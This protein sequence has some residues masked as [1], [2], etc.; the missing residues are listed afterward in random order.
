MKTMYFLQKKS[1][2]FICFSLLITSIYAGPVGKQKAQL[3]AQNFMSRE[4]KINP[5]KI[6]TTYEAIMDANKSQCVMHVFKSENS[7]IVVAADDR[8]YPILAYSTEGTYV[9]KGKVPAF[10][11]WMDN[12]SKEIAAESNFKSTV[13]QEVITAWKLY[14]SN[15]KTN[16]NTKS[17]NVVAPLVATFWNQD[18]DYNYYCPATTIAGA[19]DGKCYAGCVA[20]AMSQVMKHYNYPQQ[21]RGSYSYTH[22]AFGLLSADFANTTYNWSIM[23]PNN[24]TFIIDTV[25]RNA[26][27]K[28]MY[29]C[30]VS[31]EMDYAP[32]GSG[33]Q[34]EYAR[35]AL[36]NNFKYRRYINNANK[37]D[38]T[39]DVWRNMLMEN[40]DMGYPMIYSG[41]PGPGQTGHAWV[42]DGYDATD[43]FHFNFGW[44][45]SG[46][47]YLYLNNINSGNG[48]FSKAQSIVYNIVPDSSAYP[49]CIANKIYTAQNY[50]FTDGSYTD[51][52][53]NN[54]NCQWLIQPDT[55]GTDTLRLSFLEFRTELNKDFLTVY[56]GTTTSDSVLG[57]YTGH[58]L[59]SSLTATHGAFL[60]VFISDSVNADLGW[61]VKYSTI[62]KFIVGIQENAVATQ[63]N[64][65]PNPAHGKLS[66]SGNFKTSGNVK[67]AVSNILGAE[68]LSSEMNV[69]EGVQNKTIDISQLKAGIYMLTIEN[70]KAKS[71]T[72]FVVE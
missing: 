46:N 8:V 13:K 44:G 43:H 20:T 72:K 63:L 61:K 22:P 17:T 50:T 28:L 4:L 19:P 15:E 3:V 59:P 18:D 65:Y 47:A 49:L 24:S 26:I 5:S 52:Y 39:D 69:L 48:N 10:D 14:A 64:V 45:G 68:V 67:Y 16:L 12:L 6:P 11:W 30:G 34:S 23:P 40:L 32:S 55:L 70:D 1:I 57:T 58:T 42:C 25:G 9:G 36:Y 54:T 27:A 35:Y 60:L 66:I 38:Y 71:Y 51:N 33:T 7:Y 53:L 21:G 2:L 29:H 56:D 62:P 37:D 31:V 41:N